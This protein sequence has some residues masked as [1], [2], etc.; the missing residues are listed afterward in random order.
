[1]CRQAT[2][3]FWGALGLAAL[4]VMPATTSGQGQGQAEQPP[5]AAPVDPFGAVA[6]ARAAAAGARVRLSNAR[7][8]VSEHV[9]I[10][11]M[12]FE[13]SAAYRQA[14]ARQQQ[15]WEAFDAARNRLLASLD[16]DPEVRQTRLLLADAA[17]QVEAHQKRL[18]DPNP[19]AAVTADLRAQLAALADYRLSLGRQLSALE[20]A[21]LRD[22]PATRDARLALTEST[23]QLEELRRDF[24]LRLR[25]SPE[26]ASG[27]R[28]VREAREQHA[29]AAEYAVGTIRTADLLLDYAYYVQWLAARRPVVYSSPWLTWGYPVVGTT[30]TVTAGST[31]IGFGM[32]P[33]QSP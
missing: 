30:T 22:D 13:N 1:M 23:T 5:P 7:D 28:A 29:A 11:R 26:L 15:A 19:P 33:Y 4:L 8:E 16:T 3:R 18:T 14:L 32:M 20:S 12:L 25:T 10:Q 6:P 27:R 24:E 31:G 2:I 9:R 17:R 21:A